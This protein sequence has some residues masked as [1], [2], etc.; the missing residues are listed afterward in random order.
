[1]IRGGGE[2]AEEGARGT[3]VEMMVTVPW[4][5]AVSERRQRHPAAA[6]A[7]KRQAASAPSQ[8]SASS[9]PLPAAGAAV[10]PA[11]VGPSR[12]TIRDDVARTATQTPPPPP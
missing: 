2:A 8:P 4:P 7:W 1:M 10:T 11:C 6:A 9:L 3:E 5:L 12:Q